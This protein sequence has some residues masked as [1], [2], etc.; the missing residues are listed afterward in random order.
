MSNSYNILIERLNKFTKSY[1]I[2]MLVRG[3]FSII[4]ILL[5]LFIVFCVIEYF[6]FLNSSFR[7]I[8][9]W[10]YLSVA[11]I[12]VIKFVFFP[13]IQ[14]LQLTKRRISNKEAAKII[15]LH[16]PEIEDKLINILELKNLTEDFGGELIAASI[17]KKDVT[18]HDI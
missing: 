12:L 3:L 1:Y 9:F 16:F 13:L 11:A 6:S 14:L 15:G 7:K 18:T 2:N 8:L 4:A 10:T 5:L 17:K